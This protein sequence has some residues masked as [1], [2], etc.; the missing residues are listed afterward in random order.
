MVQRIATTTALFLTAGVSV[1]FIL[2]IGHLSKEVAVAAAEHE[3][4]KAKAEA[5]SHEPAPSQSEA[6]SLIAF[7]EIFVNVP[8]QTEKSHTLGVK[9]ELELF[10]EESRRVVEQWQ[11]VVKDAIIATT[12]EQNYDRLST[13]AGKLFFKEALVAR[14]NQLFNQALV[15]DVHF[16]S[17]YL[18]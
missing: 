14:I 2:R 18:Q 6:V 7:D 8:G 1:F 13:I 10:E 15:R 17:F 4:E 9:I 3:R 16:G 11:A 12:V 5:S